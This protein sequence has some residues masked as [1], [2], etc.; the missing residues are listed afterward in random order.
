[1]RDVRLIGLILCLTLLAAELSC[2]SSAKDRLDRDQPLD[3]TKVAFDVQSIAGTEFRNSTARVVLPASSEAAVIA[4]VQSREWDV[5]EHH[6]NGTGERSISYQYVF[7][8]IDW[9][10]N[11]SDRIPLAI[12]SKVNSLTGAI[13]LRG[14]VR[15]PDVPGFYTLEFRVTDMRE[16]VQRGPFIRF[17]HFPV[18]RIEVEVRRP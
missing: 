8:N 14:N 18:G 4:T 15:V 17:E 3:T 12:H 7:Y 6:E 2:S 5:V 1:M 13:E 11:L 16:A 9:C 10:G